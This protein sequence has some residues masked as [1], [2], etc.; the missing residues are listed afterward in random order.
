MAIC[1]H[2]PFSFQ[3][4]DD[5]MRFREVFIN[6]SYS[7]SG[8]MGLLN[9]KAPSSI[10]ENDIPL[11]LRCTS[12]G[13]PL[14]T[15]VRLFLMEVPVSAGDLSRAIAPMDIETWV[16]A[17]LLAAHGDDI[18][19]RIKLL[20]FKELLVAFDQTRILHT[21]E[22]AKYVMGI[23]ASSLTLANFTIRKPS[24]HVLDLGAGC[25][26]QALL[27]SPH[28]RQVTAIDRNPR[29]IKFSRFNAA[30]NG[31][32]NMTCVEGD[33]FAP[34]T[35]K[36]FDLIVTN[37]PFV[38]S[39]ETSYI[40]R[41]GGL[42]SDQ[43]CRKIIREASQYLT[44]GGFCQMLCN[45]AEVEGQ[46]WRDRLLEWVADL[47]CDLWVIRTDSWDAAI[48]ASKWIRHT[49]PGIGPKE[50]DEQFDQWMMYYKKEKIEAV[51]AG[52]ITLRRSMSGRS[53]WFRAE[54][55]PEKMIGPCGDD[56]LQGF[57][58]QDFLIS[59]PDDAA[60]LAT[61]FK[62]CPDIRLKQEWRF[63]D[64]GWQNESIKIERVRGLPVG[65]NIDPYVASL[66]R[67]CDGTRPLE[68]FLNE[69]AEE[70]PEIDRAALPGV[71]ARVVRSLIE[72]RFLL[73][74]VLFR[75]DATMVDSQ[76]STVDGCG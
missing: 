10:R 57:A 36:H 74:E 32:D 51:G 76:K 47:G 8:V 52:L 27:A 28:S 40:Y 5:Y 24:L 34:V 48:Y 70:F 14:E 37:P 17:G 72:Q 22:K 41:D 21:E 71:V 63:E 26:I 56:I 16:S 18:T 9:G 11:L 25:G 20:P 1:N 38:I 39:P 50:F 13:S 53:S 30:V 4:P 3:T 15:L 75:T 12:G 64:K 69:M 33:F 6:A 73:P 49:E 23:G 19:A 65:G 7:D 60:L 46:Q 54:D 59:A 68:C 31:V 62:V 66:L 42:P 55:G 29:A 43:V 67:R 35:G 44:E 61:R 2:V 45:W 58:L